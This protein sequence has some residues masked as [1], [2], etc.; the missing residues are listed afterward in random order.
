MLGSLIIAII[1][2]SI[3]MTIFIC[4]NQCK[5]SEIQFPET[6]TGRISEIAE[7]EITEIKKTKQ[8][9]ANCHTVNV[10]KMSKKGSLDTEVLLWVLFFGVFI[11]GL[12]WVFFF[13]AY[14]ERQ[15]LL[16]SLGLNKNHS[17]LWAIFGFFIFSLFLISLAYSTFYSIWRL[18][19]KSNVCTTCGSKNL[20]PLESPKAQKIL[21]K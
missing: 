19:T 5:N 10:P 21:Q 15:L 9:C 1:A 14:I 4:H 20:L 17:F 6:K 8:L 3:I 11:F 16:L 18:T 2:V 13:G 7:P 12:L